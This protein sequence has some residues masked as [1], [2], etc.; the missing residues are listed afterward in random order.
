VSPAPKN[1]YWSDPSGN[2]LILALED[3]FYLLQYNADVVEEALSTPS[4]EETEDGY[5]EAFT[6]IE[7]F[8]ETV[9]SG[10]WISNECFVF[11]TPKGIINYLITGGAG[12]VSTPRVLKL[13]NSDKK[14]FILG[15]DAKQQGGRLYLIDKSLNV[16]SYQL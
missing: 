13:A 8:H 14:Y 5:E 15:Y 2:N 4:Q 7:E 10:C 1:V 6:F 11:V 12:G 3:T 9:Q 16:I